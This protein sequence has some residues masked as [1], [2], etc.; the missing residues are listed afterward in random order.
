MHAMP[1]GERKTYPESLKNWIAIGNKL[2]H[3]AEHSGAVKHP[4]WRPR[5]QRSDLWLYPDVALTVAGC[6]KQMHNITCLSSAALLALKLLSFTGEL[7]PL[8]AFIFLQQPKIAH[9][10]KDKRFFYMWQVCVCACAHLCKCTVCKPVWG[11]CSVL[12]RWMVD[13]VEE[14]V[15]T[16]DCIPTLSCLSLAWSWVTAIFFICWGMFWSV[17]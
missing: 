2:N 1:R 5:S 16:K 17:T 10:E 8:C 7:F 6:D 15:S 9:N 13:V 11:L 14:S 12:C 3:P 4:V